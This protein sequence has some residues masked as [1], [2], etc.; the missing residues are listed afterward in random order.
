MSKILEL[1]GKSL[2][3]LVE[4]ACQELGCLPEDLEIEIKEFTLEGLLSGGRKVK[5]FF[6]IKA[7]KVLSE[8]A[9]RALIFLKDLFY[10]ADFN[11]ESQVKLRKDPLEVEIILSGEDIRH[12]RQNQGDPLSALEFLVNKIVARAL[13]VGPKIVLKSQGI[14]SKNTENKKRNSQRNKN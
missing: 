7:D 6:K 13:G 3:Q 10:N 2:D 11:L 1:E 9:N 8:R 5:A 12:L 14:R 4:K